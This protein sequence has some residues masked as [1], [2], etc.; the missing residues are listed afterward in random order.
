MQLEAETG[1]TAVLAAAVKQCRA[2]D[3]S[4]EMLMLSTADLARLAQSIDTPSEGDQVSHG[5]RSTGVEKAMEEEGASMVVEEEVVFARENLE[6]MQYRDEIYGM[7][8]PYRDAGADAADALAWPR[9]SGSGKNTGKGLG[10]S[11]LVHDFEE[12]GEEYIKLIHTLRSSS[13]EAAQFIIGAYCLYHGA[14]L[15]HGRCHGVTC[16]QYTRVSK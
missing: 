15:P 12:L 13:S 5:K 1:I 6:S 3:I 10:R 14:A 16:T 11:K 9:R 8:G 2:G 4:T 7:D